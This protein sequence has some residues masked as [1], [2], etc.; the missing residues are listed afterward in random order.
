MLCM[1]E[2]LSIGAQGEGPAI[3]IDETFKFCNT[4][5]SATFNNELLTG[6]TEG[7]FLNRFEVT[8]LEM[9]II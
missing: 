4:Y 1:P 3:Q 8:E 5:K 2:S 6:R 7:R 9:F